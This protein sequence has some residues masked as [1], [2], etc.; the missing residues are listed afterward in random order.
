MRTHGWAGHPPAD[1][2][3]AKRRILDAAAACVDR[4]GAMQASLSDVASELGVTRQ[5]VY[6]YFP[7]TEQLFVALAEE[8]ADEFIDRIVERMGRHD[9]P[10]DAL[11]EGLAFTIESIPDE[12]Y[13]G[14]LL[15]T[16]DAFSRGILSDVAMEFGRDLLARTAI[17]WDALGYREDD[18]EGL[19]EIMLR[20]IQSLA[21]SPEAPSGSPRT[22]DELRGFLRRWFAPAITATRR[23]RVTRRVRAGQ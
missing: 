2:A 19:V 16:G 5:T 1:D 18:L 12:R 17:D 4:D 15:R 3:E 13:L 20:L 7:G 22:G 8:A 6:R 21:V 9:E 11:V 14:L 10:D 23:S